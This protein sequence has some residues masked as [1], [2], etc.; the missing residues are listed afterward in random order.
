MPAIKK[1]I[2]LTIILF[3]SISGLYAQLNEVSVIGGFSANGL[4]RFAQLE[5]G[6]SYDGD[7]GWHTGLKFSKKLNKDTW[8]T[9]GLVYSQHLIT[10]TPEYFPD[11]EIVSRTEKISLI[12]IPFELRLDFLKYFFINAGASLDIDISSE[13]TGLDSQSGLGLGMGFGGKIS[14]KKIIFKVNPW[15]KIYSLLPFQLENYHQ[16]LVE[17]GVGLSVGYAF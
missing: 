7:G 8:I 12:S 1:S 11:V 2:L 9:S 16:H 17:S 13:D 15:L 6:G 4:A 5:G 10:I 14:Y 3:Q